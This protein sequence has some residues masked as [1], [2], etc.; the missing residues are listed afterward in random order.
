MAHAFERVSYKALN[1]RQRENYNSQK[2]SAVLA[3]YGFSTIRPSSDW[4]GADFIAQHLDLWASGGS[5]VL[6]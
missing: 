4:Q 5:R 3:D 2:I 1:A 6:R